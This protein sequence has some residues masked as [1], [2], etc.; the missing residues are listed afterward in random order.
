M[1]VHHDHSMLSVAS[2]A[3][4]TSGVDLRWVAMWGSAIAIFFACKWLTWRQTPHS[5]V[6]LR[7]QLGYVLAWPG[8][9]AAAFFSTSLRPAKPAFREWI[10]AAAKTFFGAFVLYV[11]CRRVQLSDP[12][13]QGWI[14][15][16]GIAF[17]LHFGSF[18]LM[19][20]AWRS[21]GV[22]ARPLMD[23]PLASVRVAD[24]WGRRW[25]TAFRDVTHRFLFRPLTRS[26]GPRAAIW[27]GFLISG[28]VH[29]VVISIPA[30]GGYGGPTLFF[31]LQPL[32]MFFERSPLGRRWG[33]GR[34]LRGWL[35]TMAFI[36]LP[37]RLLFHVPF[38]TRVIV[39]FMHAIGATP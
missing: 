2:T 20:C 3:P 17:C 32:G 4:E 39:P 23:W 18:H 13:W 28:V 35:F 11:V 19:S 30:G 22:D 24:Y 33:L 38:V 6:P 26:V 16:I 10:F 14:G 8:M 5:A 15:M 1:G 34:G 31:L 12:Y 7:R 29:D 9:D 36:L 27:L 25:N 37:A 21:A